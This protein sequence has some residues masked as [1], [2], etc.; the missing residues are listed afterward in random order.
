MDT[1]EP[2]GVGRPAIP[3]QAKRKPQDVLSDLKVALDSHGIVLPSVQMERVGYCNPAEPNP[4]IDLGRV[5]LR[6]A[7]RLIE[8]L[9]R[10]TETQP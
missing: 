6:T 7:V 2:A 3:L 5:N 9:T 4:L 10:G 8:V 1:T